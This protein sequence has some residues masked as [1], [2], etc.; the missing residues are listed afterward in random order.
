MSVI[1][2]GIIDQTDLN[3]IER[4]FSTPVGTVPF[5]RNFGVDTSI[6][7]D[8]PAATE[9]ALLIEYSTKLDVYFP[10]YQI[11]D[12]SFSVDGNTVTPKVVIGYA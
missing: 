3:C 8:V 10:Q 1:V 4:L 9:G 6:L 2:S 12:I 5:D 11:S 7:D